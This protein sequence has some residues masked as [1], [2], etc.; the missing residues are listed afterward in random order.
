MTIM[1]NV[2]L[3]RRLSWKH[4]GKTLRIEGLALHPGTFTGLDGHTITYPPEIFDDNHIEIAERR[5]KYRHEDS[6]TS[7]IGFITGY[8]VKPDGLYIRGYV[9]DEGVAELIR[10]GEVDGLSIEAEVDVDQEMR[11]KKVKITA[12][13]IVP[14][15][16]APKAGILTSRIVALLGRNAENNVKGG[17]MP[18]KPTREEF[19]DWIKKQLEDA[20]VPK[21]I[22]ETVMEVLD[23][24]IKTPYPYPYPE[25]KVSEEEYKALQEENERLK[26]E[27]EEL[28]KK[29]EELQLEAEVK[30]IKSVEPDFEP[31]KVFSENMS[32]EA[33]MAALKAYK[34]AMKVKITVTNASAED[35]KFE[36]KVEKILGELGIGGK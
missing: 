22:V 5:L 28:K 14:N 21:D 6:D 27:N 9:F 11:A 1:I 3:R 10:N 31:E 29:L 12:V 26:K 15:P 2:C 16:A 17:E 23:K 35:K 4:V 18:E 8:D 36:E 33:K 20:N 34:E 24:A 30:E 13:A 25:P 7:V 19:M 32:F